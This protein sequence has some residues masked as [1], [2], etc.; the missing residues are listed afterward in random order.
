MKTKMVIAESQCLL[1]ELLMLAVSNEGQVLVAGQ[2]ASGSE[3]LEI[4][5][6]QP[7]ELLL[8]GCALE[9]MSCTTLVRRVHAE[10]PQIRLLVLAGEGSDEM[11]ALPLRE[12]PHGMFHRHDSLAV[13]YDA[14]RAVVRGAH[15]H[16]GQVIHHAAGGG[17]SGKTGPMKLTSREKDVLGLLAR[18]RS[19]KQ[20]AHDLKLSPKTVDHYRADLMKKLDIHDVAGLTKHALKAGLVTLE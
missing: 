7:P 3:V 5:S 2:C 17:Q 19:S 9:D 15:Y 18:G 6:K 20:I 10:H 8:I 13:L 1:R 4:C 16:S 14:L 12:Q 11:L